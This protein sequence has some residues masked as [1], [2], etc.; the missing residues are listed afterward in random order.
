[1]LFYLEMSLNS[2]KF[3]GIFDFDYLVFE[4]VFF[5]FVEFR[6]VVNRFNDD[7]EF[8]CVECIVFY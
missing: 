7:F 1:M 2:E 4:M 6:E 8:F 3:K 5:S